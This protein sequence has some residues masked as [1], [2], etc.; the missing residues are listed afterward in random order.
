MFI[1]RKNTAGVKP[2]AD[3]PKRPAPEGGAK[4]PLMCDERPSD[5]V[6]TAQLEDSSPTKAQ[7]NRRSIETTDPGASAK[8][9]E[10]QERK[11]QETAKA[12]AAAAAAADPK[13]EQPST[14][15]LEKLFKDNVITDADPDGANDNGP[16]ATPASPRL[17]SG[18]GAVESPSGK[19]PASS[20]DLQ[21]AQPF[22]EP[23]VVEPSA[24]IQQKAALDRKNTALGA[25]D[26]GMILDDLDDRYS[27]V[28]AHRRGS[29][30]ADADEAVAAAAAAKASA[31]T[32]RPPSARPSSAVSISDVGAGAL[33]SAPPTP[34]RPAR[35]PSPLPSMP[36]TETDASGPIQPAKLEERPSSAQPDDMMGPAGG[37]TRM[38]GAGRPMSAQQRQQPVGAGPLGGSR[39]PASAGGDRGEPVPATGPPG[40]P[41]PDAKEGW[42]TPPQSS[43]EAQMSEEQKKRM[44]R[45]E[46]WFERNDPKGGRG[47]GR[48]A[49]QRPPGMPKQKSLARTGSAARR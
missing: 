40:T 29:F 36:E 34:P 15:S 47:G 21:D 8:R 42:R 28:D 20:T 7:R 43:P 14:T 44:N 27:A 1:R 19:Q 25:A 31:G 38:L 48:G 16:D 2:K 35:S 33:S 45:T 18:I 13:I 6:E 4:D 41:P 5:D 17:M 37:S 23:A 9:E 32:S 11:K 30:S 26:M 24:P 3:S 49:Q 10:E 46:S 22:V 39:R 12:A